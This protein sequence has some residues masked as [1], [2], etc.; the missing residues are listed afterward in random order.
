[1][2]V[3]GETPLSIIQKI[4]D[5][6]LMSILVSETNKYA[7][8]VLDK[9]KSAQPRMVRWQNTSIDEMCILAAVTVRGERDYELSAFLRSAL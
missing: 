1:M 3:N 6:E 7:Q 5:V 9:E 2:P 8:T 4:W